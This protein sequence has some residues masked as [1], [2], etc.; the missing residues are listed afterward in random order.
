MPRKKS[1]G[2]EGEAVTP[3]SLGPEAEDRVAE[4]ARDEPLP[5]AGAESE[6]PAEAPES[7]P[8]TGDEP[9]AEPVTADVAAVPQPPEEATGPEIA[10]EP[11]PEPETV[12]S[13]PASLSA[14]DEPS[15]RRAERHAEEVHVEEEGPEEAGSSFAARALTF[16]VLLLAGAALGIWAAPRVAPH[17]PSG[18]QPVADW[19]TPGRTE[20]A[21]EMAALRAHVDQ[22]LGG[23][24]ARIADLG[25]PDDLDARITSA[26][27]AAESR[28][29]G[30]IAAVRDSVGQFDDT[31]LRQRLS[32]LE[33]SLQGQVAEVD[34]L[35]QQLSGTTATTG[36]LSEQAAQQIDVYRAEVDGLRAE[37]GTL[38][39]Q[40]SALGA[41]IDEVA[42]EADRQITT[43]QSKVDEIQTQADTQV[44]AAAVAAD[45]AQVRAAL[46]SGQPF[47]GA[48]DGL[49]QAN[50][51]VPASLADAAAAGVE[52]LPAL[53]DAFPDAAHAAIRSS[54]M[55]GAGDGVLARSRA[56]LE[57]QVASRSLSPRPG[58][59]PDAI[60]SRMEDDLRRDDLKAALAEAEQLPTE[61]AAA[62]RD[63]LD[64]ARLRAAADDAIAEL[65]S[66]APT[67]N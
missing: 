55:A 17:L 3:E 63:W 48:I 39:D 10:P 49:K 32:R 30:E 7:A 51:A 4:P 47:A 53:R 67:T 29:A 41:R 61:A 12:L 15:G 65:P 38:Q 23:V 28:I 9:A 21:A 36:Q 8:P 19:L 46:A 40:V 16:L 27:G 22:G 57:A 14:L 66:S 33:A 45:V 20:A 24:E 26:V 35:K 18:M 25:P 64:A 42:A 60:L 50:V 31:E 34:E 52:T 1:D 58:T 56:F 37:M 13:E 59:S 5:P 11:M 6:P 2:T 54:I 44:G 43:A 62:M